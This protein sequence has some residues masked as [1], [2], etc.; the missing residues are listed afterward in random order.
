MEGRKKSPMRL[1]R[2]LRLGKMA[3]EALYRAEGNQKRLDLANDALLALSDR[4]WSLQQQVWRLERESASTDSVPRSAAP[5]LPAR[6]NGI[7]STNG[8]ISAPRT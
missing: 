6:R 8:A 5:S 7:P 1:R 2:W 4:M 3:A